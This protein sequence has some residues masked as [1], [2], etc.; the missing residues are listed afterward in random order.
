L[1]NFSFREYNP[2]LFEVENRHCPI[3]DKKIKAGDFIH[4][5]SD[6]A[7][8][9]NEEAYRRKEIEA[10][11]ATEDILDVENKTFGDKLID[12]KIIKDE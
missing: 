6:R 7:L 3:C 4:Q 8:Q 10:D 2:Q 5:C 1:E 9:A 12:A 11:I